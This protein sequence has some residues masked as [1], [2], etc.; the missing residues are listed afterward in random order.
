MLDDPIQSVSIMQCSSYGSFQKVQRQT[1]QKLY[2]SIEKVP[3]KY[4]VNLSTIYW[5]LK[6]VSVK[7]IL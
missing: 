6:K 5:L 3:T 7:E 4:L 2:V 1:A